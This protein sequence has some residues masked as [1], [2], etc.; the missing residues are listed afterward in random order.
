MLLFKHL[1][2]MINFTLVVTL[3]TQKYISNDTDIYINFVESVNKKNIKFFNLFL[4]SH[5]LFF[6]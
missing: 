3:I 5:F 2:H 4:I 1:I 6:F